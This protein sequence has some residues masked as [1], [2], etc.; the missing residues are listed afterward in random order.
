MKLYV[1]WIASFILC[2]F[3]ISFCFFAPYIID[4]YYQ[5]IL[6]SKNLQDMGQFGDLFGSVNALFSGLA[7]AGLAVTIF[8][9]KIALKEARDANKK[10]EKVLEIQ[11]F[12]N[13]LFNLLKLRNDFAQSIEIKKYKEGGLTK[14]PLGLAF[15][16]NDIH[17]LYNGSQSNDT[18]GD[19][20]NNANLAYELCYKDNNHA[21]SSYFR[22]LFGVFDFID[23]STLEIDKKKQYCRYVKYQLSDPE[24][25]LLFY[26]ICVYGDNAGRAE[27]FRDLAIKFELLNN[28][29]EDEVI[30][31]EFFKKIDPRA[32]GRRIPK[33]LL[34]AS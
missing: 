10:Q 25:V 6:F 29:Q 24:T 15:L 9:Q 1:V 33:Y 17:A 18:P 19:V 5:P 27:K 14:G 2:A 16:L 8:L 22:S 11:S 3:I 7:F 13:T 23:K 26:N 21:L 12:E 34:E 32:Y 31:K 20:H 4:K 30:C 28:L